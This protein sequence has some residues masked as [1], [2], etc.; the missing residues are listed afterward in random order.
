VN[1]QPCKDVGFH[2]R[3]DVELRFWNRERSAE[4]GFIARFPLGGR[5]VF[6]GGYLELDYANSPAPLAH[7]LGRRWYL[8]ASPLE[9]RFPSAAQRMR[10]IGNE[11][12]LDFRLSGATDFKRL[13]AAVEAITGKHFDAYETVLDWGCGCGRVARHVSGAADETSFFGCDI[14]RENVAWCSANL[15]GSYHWTT[16][17]PPLPFPDAKFDLVYG[18]SVFTHLGAELQDAW[19]EELRRVIRPGGYLC[20]TVHGRTAL[21]YAGMEPNAY[22]SLLGK[23]DRSGLV[24]AGANSQLDGATAD[25]HEYLNVFHTKKYIREHW[26]RWFSVEEIL[27]GYIYTHDLVVL[28][29]S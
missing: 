22:V 20:V 21:D 25:A 5:Q 28:R 11:D 15:V 12:L 23:L 13:C 7:G 29:R 17:R 26:A 24:E 6:P 10:V 14:D 8:R 1:G 2:D 27:P 18:V 3:I 9:Q 19:L 16:M 4:S